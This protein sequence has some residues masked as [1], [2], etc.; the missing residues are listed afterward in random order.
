MQTLLCHYADPFSKL[1]VQGR[2]RR[3]KLGPTGPFFKVEQLDDMVELQPFE[4]ATNRTSLVL[5][6]KSKKI[7]YPSTLSPM[8]EE[9][10]R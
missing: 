5:F 6:K 10:E 9:G 3:F 8:E 7:N 1:Q 4:G 2:L